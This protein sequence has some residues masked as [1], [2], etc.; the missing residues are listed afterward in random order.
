ME[1]DNCKGKRAMKA[2]YLVLDL[3]N[4]LVHEDGPNGKG[5]LGEQIRS[6]RI[7]ANTSQAIAKARAA[8]VPI[9]F[10]RVGFSPDYRECSST[11]PM[12]SGIR[13]AGLLKLGTWGT[14]IHPSLDRQ[15]ADVLLTKHRVSP[16]YGTS[17]EVLLRAWAVDRL[18]L[19]GV[20]TSAVVQATVRE[21]HDR[22]YNCTV[23][24]DGCAAALA[25]EHTASIE[26]LRRFA[27]IQTSD[28]LAF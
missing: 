22:D 12:F 7:L 21:A 25:S 20:S 2:A 15:H 9:V 5:P 17:L 24:E 23:L 11:S 14:E 27:E 16:F 3:Q 26:V 8:A 4:D 1:I 6:R 19:S 28:S 10:V 13:K 18:V